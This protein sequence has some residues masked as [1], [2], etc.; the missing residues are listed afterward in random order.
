[1]KNV[2]THFKNTGN[3]FLS[4]F[5]GSPKYKNVKLV[6]PSDA[7]Y[8]AYYREHI[9]ARKSTRPVGYI[10]EQ[11]SVLCRASKTVEH[12]IR[13]WHGSLPNR[14]I[15]YDVLYNGVY[16]RHY[17]ECDIIREETDG[18]ITIGEV[19]SSHTPSPGKAASQLQHSAE[20]LSTVFPDV[21]TVAITVNMASPNPTRNLDHFDTTEHQSMTGFKFSGL[22]LSLGDIVDFARNNDLSVDFDLFKKANKEAMECVQKRKE[23]Q[24]LRFLQSSQPDSTTTVTVSPFGML[25]QNALGHNRSHYKYL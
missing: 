23:K 19:K 12:V 9:S 18:S 22:S 1:M 7:S 25:L 20:I 17:K 8:Q 6:H 4:H 10:T 21:N 16:H 14:I 13:Y 5:Y 3:S 15:Q 24:Q 11:P 2:T